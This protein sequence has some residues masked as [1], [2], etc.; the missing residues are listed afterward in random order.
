MILT[1][2]SAIAHVWEMAQYRANPLGQGS[3]FSAAEV[4]GHVPGLE[5]GPPGLECETRPP[6]TRRQA[7]RLRPIPFVRHL[8]IQRWTSECPCVASEPAVWE[9]VFKD[10][11]RFH[12][13]AA[14]GTGGSGRIVPARGKESIEGRIPVI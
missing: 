14:G 12:E 11:D 2:V 7:W 10:R 8:E 1:E 3:M 9:D 6:S 5:Q 13:E 4:F